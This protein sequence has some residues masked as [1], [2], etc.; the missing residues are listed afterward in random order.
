M[1]NVTR[2]CERLLNIAAL[3]CLKFI[4]TAYKYM[5]LLY[6]LN[7]HHY[8][9]KHL[10]TLILYNANM[11]YHVNQHKLHVTLAFVEYYI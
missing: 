4:S 1:V 7:L 11:Y 2:K 3:D 6:T 8:N 10:H 5:T 9:P